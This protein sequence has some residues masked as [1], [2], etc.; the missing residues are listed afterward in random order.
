MLKLPGDEFVTIE[1]VHNPNETDVNG[2]TRLSHFVIQV[3]HEGARYSGAVLARRA[4]VWPGW[5]LDQ[6]FREA[7]PPS[8]SRHG[9]DPTPC[10]QAHDAAVVVDVGRTR[11][12]S[13]AVAPSP[14]SRC[15]SAIRWRQRAGGLS[16]SR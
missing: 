12:R 5:R 15:T 3:T 8:M 16:F 11:R 2:G 4:G 9:P 10:H 13:C 6:G 7:D 1:L 14:H